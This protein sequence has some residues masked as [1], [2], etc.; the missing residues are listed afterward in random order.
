M[1]NGR[2]GTN[3]NAKVRNNLR[4]FCNGGSIDAQFM[5]NSCAMDG[6]RNFG[7]GGIFRG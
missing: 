7:A 5:R 3:I 6:A 4:T 1:I 2:K